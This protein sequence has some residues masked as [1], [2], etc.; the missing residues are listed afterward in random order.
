MLRDIYTGVNEE[1]IDVYLE[2]LATPEALS[3][4]LNWYRALNF[5]SSLVV[6]QIGLPTLFIWSD[7]DAA[8]GPDGAMFTVNFVDGPYKLEILKGVNHWVT[9]ITPEAVSQ[10]LLEH[11]EAYSEQID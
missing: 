2:A 5:G 7:E 10:L 9:D 3:A 1:D 8:L 11:I 6:G 4:A